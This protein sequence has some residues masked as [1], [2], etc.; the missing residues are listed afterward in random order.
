M[1]N[2]LLAT[3]KERVEEIILESNQIH[4]ILD[5]AGIQKESIGN[6]LFADSLFTSLLASLLF[7]SKVLAQPKLEAF[8]CKRISKFIEE[9]QTDKK[10][11]K[12]IG[13]IGDIMNDHFAYLENTKKR[14]ADWVE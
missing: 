1:E 10:I 3:N 5:E 11:K 14:F 13:N 8:I 9:Y 6:A 7:N 12:Q 4:E 2:H